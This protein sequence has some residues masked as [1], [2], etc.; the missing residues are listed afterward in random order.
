MVDSGPGR[1]TSL[2]DKPLNKLSSK[3][4]EINISAFALLFR[5]MVNYCDSRVTTID[6][7]QAGTRLKNVDLFKTV[8]E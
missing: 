7:H 2:V 1:A 8:N 5:E 6:E 3:H 4:A